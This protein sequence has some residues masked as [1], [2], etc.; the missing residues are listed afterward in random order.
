MRWR[1]LGKRPGSAVSA[2]T[3]FIQKVICRIFSLRT[4]EAEQC[5]LG[6]HCDWKQ[7]VGRVAEEGRGTVCEKQGEILVPARG[8]GKRKR[9]QGGGRALN[10]TTIY[11]RGKSDDGVVPGAGRCSGRRVEGMG[12]LRRGLCIIRDWY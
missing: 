1:R 10:H 8:R 3:V 2:R 5:S 11:V 9:G 7:D 4:W 12:D 6:T